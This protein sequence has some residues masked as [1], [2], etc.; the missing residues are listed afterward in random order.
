MSV[1]PEKREDLIAMGY[2]YTGN[3]RCRGC[4]AEIEWWITRNGKRMPMRVFEEGNG[5]MQEHTGRVGFFRRVHFEDCP[6][7]AGFRKAK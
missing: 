3:G 7:A 5:L 4:G 1:I 2:V 6:A